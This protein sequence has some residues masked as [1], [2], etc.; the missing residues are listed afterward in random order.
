MSF[1]DSNILICLIFTL[2]SILNT[3]FCLD[4]SYFEFN[5]IFYRQTT[6]GTMGSPLFVELAEIRVADAEQTTLNT[7]PDPPHTYRHFVD[8]GIGDFRDKQH[9]DNTQTTWT[10]STLTYNTPLN[11]PPTTVPFLSS[12]SSILIHPDKST[13]VYRKPTHTNLYVKYNSCT[14]NST[15]NSVIRSLTRRA[16]NL[17]S[18]Q[19]LKAELQTVRDICLKNGFPIYRIDSIMSEVKFKFD[20]LRRL[21]SSS[22]QQQNF[23]S[24][25]T[26]NRDF[27]A[28]S[29]P[30]Q[31]NLPYHHT[32][33]KPLK[34]ILERHDIKVVH[35]SSTNLRNL[36]TKTKSSPPTHTTPNVIYNIPC[37]DCP[38]T[39]TGQ[40]RRPL[41]KRI[42]EHERHY[43]LKNATDE[44]TGNVK[45]APALH[46]LTT[47]HS[48]NWNGT[49]ILTTTTTSSQLDLTEHAAIQVLKP[50]LNR[51]DKAPNIKTLRNPLLPKIARSFKRRPAEITKF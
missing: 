21:N 43:R 14:P 23:M 19:H 48:I 45:T 41:I 36:I 28:N 30:L 29:F 15:K 39:Y 18:P 4:Q 25:K 3:N 17:C 2:L 37:N 34:K 50:S 26:F 49:T 47:G 20:R 24:Y 46:G 40:T 42:E 6:G 44:S 33:S 38:A 10:P 35:S 13:S 27:K 11:T 5:G 22:T 32:L 9:A 12:T 1:N 8:D 16:Y 31:V 51:T 7:F